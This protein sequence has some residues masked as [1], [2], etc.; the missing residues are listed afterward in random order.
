M[1]VEKAIAELLIGKEKV[2]DVKVFH[3]IISD[4]APEC[5]KDRKVL[6]ATIDE[7]IFSLIIHE[8]PQLSEETKARVRYI[9]AEE[10]GLSDSWINITFSL[11]ERA[12]TIVSKDMTT[13][14]P[15]IF[16][17]EKVQ[18]ANKESKPNNDNK[19]SNTGVQQTENACS[20]AA[21]SN[22]NLK[23]NTNSPI[24]GSIIE[25]T[26]GKRIVPPESILIGSTVSF[27]SYK[28]SG[29]SDDKQPIE[30]LVLA[31]QNRRVLLLSKYALDNSEY[32]SSTQYGLLSSVLF[33]TYGVT[34]E[35]CFLR[36]WLNI[37]FY[38]EAFST[39]EQKMIS[40]VKITNGSISSRKQ[41]NDTLDKVFLLSCEE[42]SELLPTCAARRC[43]LTMSMRTSQ[44]I[45]ADWWLRTVSTQRTRVAYVDRR[46]S[47][48]RYGSSCSNTLSIRPAMWIE[49]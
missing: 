3:A 22:T 31:K 28:Q 45:Y 24:G 16:S 42:A 23:S 1:L 35:K 43:Q 7:N 2:T 11:F 46:G 30:W 41:G 48:D 38:N 8:A 25:L 49:L 26:P 14:S 36:E 32:D 20:N 44:R 37:G 33:F 29:D 47:I 6:R 39:R 17:A 12:F 18:G 13:S 5:V 15:H 34:W 4:L 40:S 9:L 10:K 27:G 21:I 19:H